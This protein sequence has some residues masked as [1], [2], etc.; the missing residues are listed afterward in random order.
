MFRNPFISNFLS[1]ILSKCILC[2]DDLHSKWELG[3]ILKQILSDFIYLDVVA[4]LNYCKYDS[5]FFE[6][7]INYDYENK[8]TQLG[9]V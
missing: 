4:K 5:T 2:Q 6:E 7:S 1:L 8:K 9:S 3:A